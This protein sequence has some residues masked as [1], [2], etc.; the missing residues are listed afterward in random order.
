M[1][2]EIEDEMRTW[3]GRRNAFSS[4]FQISPNIRFLNNTFVRLTRRPSNQKRTIN[5]GH[6]HS[7]SSAFQQSLSSKDPSWTTR[8]GLRHTRGDPERRLSGSH[9]PSKRLQ[10]GQVGGKERRSSR[11][12]RE[13]WAWTGGAETTGKSGQRKGGG[14]EREIH[15][16]R[17]HLRK[18]IRELRMNTSCSR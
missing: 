16:R 6:H 12:Q 17:E 13:R 10:P 3:E 11:V 1:H 14:E 4:L 2:R 18:R 9:L 7:E 5:P 8:H 15:E